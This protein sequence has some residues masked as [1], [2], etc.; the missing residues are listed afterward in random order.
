MNGTNI[1]TAS[2]L[3]ASSLV[4][5]A[6]AFS[7]YQK[8]KLEKEILIG[9]LRA[10][11][12]LLVVGYLLEYIFGMENPLFTTLLIL[13][14]TFNA[15]MNAAKRGEGIE[16]GFA[17]SFVSILAGTVVTL[18]ILVLS[19]A[20]KYEPYQIIPISGMVISNAMV[21]LGLCF[22]NITSQFRSRR[23]EVEI[24]LSLGA[25]MMTAAKGIIRDS[26]R[27]AL[28]PTI[29]SAKTMGIVALPG[30]M[31]GLILAGTSPIFAVKYQIM[32][33][34]MMFSTTSIASMI[35]CYLAYRKFFNN[36]QQL[37]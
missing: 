17:I 28:L 24:K 29:D 22:R 36:R 3:A 6:I 5:I 16:N 32:V 8:L 11:V 35:A 37:I 4:M 23:E 20:I 25:D 31:T 10:V 27:T 30:T 33:V 15:A 1:S 34:F 2:L 9:I 18:S 13:F 21:A 14:M 26:I 19:K 12:Q 7:Y